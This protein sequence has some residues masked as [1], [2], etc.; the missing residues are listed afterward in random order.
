MLKKGTITPRDEALY[1]LLQDRNLIYD[2]EKKCNHCC[3][4]RKT[5]DHLAT[6]CDRMLSYDYKDRHDAILKSIHLKIAKENKLVVNKKLKGYEVQPMLQNKDIEIRTDTVI[7]LDNK[8]QCNR[9]DMV[10][11]NQKIKRITII[12]IGVTS[13]KNIKE[14]ECHKK[15]K[16]DMLANELPSI[17]QY[18]VE[19]IPFVI[20][21]DGLVT[22]Y[23]KNYSIMLGINPKIFSYIQTVPLKKTLESISLDFRRNFDN[24]DERKEELSKKNKTF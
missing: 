24:K 10:I 19:I 21:W 20:T 14:V 5:I 23:N 1:C 13:S 2:K 4:N 15:I 9:P 16:Y 11:F 8:V 18:Y 22:R 12:E 17:Y 6:Q 7:R 3:I